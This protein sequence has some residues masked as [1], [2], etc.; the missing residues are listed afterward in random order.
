[1]YAVFSIHQIC[2]HRFNAIN[3]IFFPDFET[4]TNIYIKELKLLVLY[5]L[6]IRP[7][8]CKTKANVGTNRLTFSKKPKK[9]KD[10]T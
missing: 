1:M 10:I 6:L 2:G 7:E 4:I 8:I 9:K 5:E 3:S